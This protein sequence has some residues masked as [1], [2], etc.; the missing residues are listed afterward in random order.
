M[1]KLVLIAAALLLASCGLYKKYDTPAFDGVK[2]AEEV[3]VVGWREMFTDPLLQGLIETALQ[4]NVDMQAALLRVDQARAALA[5]SRAAYWP[6]L[7]ANAGAGVPGTPL[8]GSPSGYLTLGARADWQLDIFGSRLNASRSSAA[9]LAQREAYAQAVR[10]DLIAS[11]AEYY[12]SL[13]SLDEQLRISEEALLTWDST[14]KVLSSLKAA[15]KTNEVAVLQAEARRLKIEASVVSLRKSITDTETALRLLLGVAEANSTEVSPSGPPA[16]DPGAPGNSPISGVNTRVIRPSGTDA[17]ATIPRDS[18]GSAVFPEAF[19]TSIQ[20]GTVAMR[21]DVK[22]AEAA[23][24][25]AWYDANAARAALYPTLSLSG[26]LGWT[27]TNGTISD[28]SSW[29]WNALASLTQPIINGRAARSKSQV[30]KDEAEIAKLQY[31]Q[32][33]LRAGAD[34]NR[35]LVA[36]QAA[37]ER[38]TLGEQQ[39]EALR[40]TVERIELLM[41]YS[42]T[43]YLEVLTAQQS[44]LDAELSLVADKAALASASIALF[45]AVGGGAN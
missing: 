12:Y 42:T 45:R 21:P 24:A 17:S 6:S 3:K 35:A 25:A 32:A 28:P 13:A 23:L 43:T 22:Q 15:G 39:Q 29:I 7:S 36:C 18:L 19:M 31:R 38:I 40:Q 37:R 10:A 14:I 8:D 27:S 44:F 1:K 16:S 4:N 9:A 2:S 5:A 20:L 41:R 11:V 30:A 33:L 34:V 26:T